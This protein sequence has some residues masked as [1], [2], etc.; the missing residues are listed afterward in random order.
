MRIGE[1]CA[2]S[3]AEVEGNTLKVRH[4]ILQPK[5]GAIRTAKLKTPQSRRDIPMPKEMMDRL[6]NAGQVSGIYITSDS[7][8]GYLTPNNATRELT[9]ACERAGLG[10]YIERKGK[11]VFV[12]LVSPHELRH[13][14][15]SLME[16]ELEAPPAIVA[17]LLGRK[18]EGLNAGYSHTH[19]KQLAKWMEKYWVRMSTS[20]RQIDLSHTG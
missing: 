14:F 5:G 11:K 18:Y 17:C 6:R 8:G 16:N 7:K 3:W 2:P 12:P 9:E 1:A 15:T 10:N 19:E 20:V 4:Q 13:T